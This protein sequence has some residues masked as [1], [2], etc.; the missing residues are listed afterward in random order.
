MGAGEGESARRAGANAMPADAV[1]NA[2]AAIWTEASRVES[3]CRGW[4][5]TGE[6]AKRGDTS[7]PGAVRIRAKCY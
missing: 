1:A 7:Q 4:A 3:S 5:M 6:H 2:P